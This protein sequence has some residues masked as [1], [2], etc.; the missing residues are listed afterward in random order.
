MQTLVLSSISM[1]C[2]KIA[3]LV[4]RTVNIQGEDQKKAYKPEDR[5]NHFWKE[6]YFCKRNRKLFNFNLDYYK[7]NV[8]QCLNC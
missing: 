6:A 1:A 4:Q 7:K 8:G 5:K 2:K 3:Y